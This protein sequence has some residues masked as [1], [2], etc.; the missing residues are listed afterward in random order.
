VL[1]Q[2]ADASGLVSALQEAGITQVSP[3][4][5]GRVAVSGATVQ[6]IGDVSA[7]ASIAVYGMQEETADLERMFFQLT[8]GQYAAPPPGFQ[9]GPPP[10]YQGPPPGYQG[11]PPGY[12]GPPPGYA[13]QNTP[14]PGFAPPQQFQQQGQPPQQPQYQQAPPQQQAQQQGQNEGWGGQG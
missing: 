1:V 11:P 2:S 13:P 9:Q 10:G 12:Q 7:K 14:P 6:Q 8:Q 3:M 5:D 4:P